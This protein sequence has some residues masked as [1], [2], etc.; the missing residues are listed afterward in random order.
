VSG[1]PPKLVFCDANVVFAAAIS[2]EGRSSSL[3]AGA[4]A[5]RYR[6]IG[7]AHVVE[8]ARRNVAA[9]YPE[10]IGRLEELLTS[11]DVSPE[12]PAEIVAWAMRQ[13][14]PDND[15]PVLAAAV[16][17]GCDLL[18]TGDRTHFGDLFGRT[19]RGVRVI[20]LREASEA[21]S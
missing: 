10:S 4:E 15:A 13:N 5:G 21:L 17:R 14:L 3:F 9:R 11:L 8:E 2:P 18:V 16:H 6:L 1:D 19:L 20:S 7:S 12:P